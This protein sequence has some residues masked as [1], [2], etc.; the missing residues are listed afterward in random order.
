[1]IS[2]VPL[3]GGGFIAR[4]FMNMVPGEYQIIHSYCTKSIRDNMLITYFTPACNIFVS[5]VR[6]PC[7][8]IAPY[9]CFVRAR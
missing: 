9:F 8:D 7:I 5:L 4:G 3:F 6:D 1:M 2:G